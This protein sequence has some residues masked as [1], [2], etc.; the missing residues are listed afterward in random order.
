L[1]HM[2]IAFLSFYNGLNF[3]G[4]ETFVHE[5]GNRL[6]DRGHQV[7]VF[8]YGPE[9]K[10]TKYQVDSLASIYSLPDMLF[11]PPDIIFPLNGRVQ[12]IRTKIWAYGHRKKMVISGQSGPGLD[13]RLNLYT[14]PD[15]FI[16]LTDF[17]CVWAKKVNP[18]V[19]VV[20]IPNGVDTSRFHPGV[21]PVN[22]GLPHPVI[23]Y[24]AALEPIKRQ[25]LLIRAI[26]KTKAS[27][28]LVG[29]GSLT[30][31]LTEMCQR[32]LPNRYRIMTFSLAEMPSVYTACDLFTY[33]TS[34]WESFGIAILEAMASGLAVVADDDP[35][36]REIIGPAGL[37]V[38]PINIETYA[39]SLETALA[40]KW[41]TKP[42]D[43]ANLYKWDKIAADYSDLFTHLVQTT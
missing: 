21:K 28:L 34:P 20:K 31:P 27:L 18:Y 26:A 15:T 23:L 9:M 30:E 39:K 17:Q 7:T 8:Q 1:N 37:F 38:N 24:V 14:L 4:V 12:A 19:K 5:L 25:E 3:R 35:I 43:R 6:T 41:G 10:N 42:A 22:H 33:P 29:H 16:G 40:E 36:R 2:R 32:L 13:D 11:P